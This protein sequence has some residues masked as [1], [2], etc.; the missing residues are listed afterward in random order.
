MFEA[1]HKMEYVTNADEFGFERGTAQAE[2][3]LVLR[4]LT[5]R[6]GAIAPETEAQIAH[7]HC[8]N[9]RS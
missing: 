6:V 7:S 9:L 1:K 5:R 4:L 8:L 2:R 3:S